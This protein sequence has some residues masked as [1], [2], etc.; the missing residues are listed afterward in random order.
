LLVGID[1]YELE[2]IVEYQE[3]WQIID[4]LGQGGQGK[5]YRVLD[6]SKFKIDQNILPQISNLL[7]AFT[8]EK[9][10]KSIKKRFPS[11]RNLLSALHSMDDS[12]NHGALKILHEPQ[13]A[14][15]PDR[16]EKRITDEIRAMA[17]VEH[18]NLLKILDHDDKWFVSQFHPKGSIIKNKKQFIGNF[19]GALKAFR[20]LVEGVSEL[21]KRGWVHR[22]IK[23]E[24][25]FVDLDNNLILGDFGLIFF[26]DTQHTRVSGTWENVGSRDWM[27]AWAMGMRI[28][29]IKPTFDVF[30]LGKLLWAMI[31]EKPT[32][33][34]WYYEDDEFN[35]VK[36]FPKSQY[37]YMANL[38]FKKCIVEREKDCIPDAT[39]LLAEI[40]RII[41][42]TG[43]QADVLDKKIK[44]VCKVCGI[45]KYIL[46]IDTDSPPG[47]LRNFGL[48]AVSGQYFKIFIC[49]HCGH[50]Q[51]FSF[52]ERSNP[53]AWGD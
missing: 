13:E 29:E 35:L 23:P 53:P 28:E 31:S 36:M 49:N 43:V 8:S 10:V 22:D 30:C 24:N 9:D 19:I 14:R 2:D 37:I 47:R 26:T 6:D 40:D 18:P 20:P 33:R 5:V 25:I 46:K 51:F 1:K 11:L 16:A 50:V 42:L 12:A 27:P 44:R 41:S 48:N 17:E 15:D 52:G 39:A 3:R 32:L 45:G 38:L 21:H 4:E 34:L 7:N